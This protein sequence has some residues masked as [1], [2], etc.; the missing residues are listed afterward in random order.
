MRALALTL[1][2]AWSLA[3]VLP[4]EKYGLVFQEAEGAWVYQAPGVRYVYLPGVGWVEPDRPDLPPPGVEGLEVGLLEALGYFR[5]PRAGVRLGGRPGARRVV[6]DLLEP[7]PGPARTGEG[8]ILLPY[9]AP[10]ALAL[11][12]EGF[13]VRLLPEGTELTPLR[14][15][16][17]RLFPL[18]DP[19]R[20][21]LDLY[22]ERAEA[23]AP[24]VVYRET[25]LFTP[26]ALRVYLVEARGGRLLPVGKPGQ[27]ALGRDLAPGALALLNG[28]YFDPRTATP[29]G[30][31]VREGVTLSYPYGRYALLWNRW[32]FFLA[33]PR[34]EALVRGPGG[35]LRVGL[36]L[37]PARY[38]AY[39]L[40]PAGRPGEEVALVVGGR[41]EGVVPAPAELPPGAWG[42]AF[43]EGSP[44]F[45]LE[46]GTP[47]SL[48][49]RLDPP[50]DFGLE[51]GPL[52]VLEGRYALDPAQEGFR[53]PRPLQAQA[54]QAAVA[55]F[56]DGR[57]WLLVS[58][59]ATPDRLARGLLA[60]GVWG[61]LRMD[62]GGSAQLWV[63]GSLKGPNGQ[64]PRPL[65]NGLA[66]YPP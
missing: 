3:Q 11:E 10:G 24:G 5:V 30:L 23:L 26:E 47:L 25:V 2:W 34:Y 8:P 1:F 62:G 64:N 20:L 56:R 45:P 29:I 6:L 9:L 48:Y 15:H 50:V 16:R 58:E 54:P 21:V 14:P 49:G 7:H 27:R 41:V 55:L 12:E 31:W 17:H 19:L 53:D 59:A 13:R 35:V 65:M 43:P 22:E 44:P 52:L 36:N 51:A 28:G 39:T 42:L 32:D 4:P 61:A 63:R 33:R 57:L 60:E 66:L 46:P 18:L 40:G 38:T 37:L